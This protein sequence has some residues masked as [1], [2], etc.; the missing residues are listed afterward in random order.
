[1]DVSQTKFTTH[2]SQAVFSGEL[3]VWDVYIGGD[4]EVSYPAALLKV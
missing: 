3:G 4:W 1:M 2:E